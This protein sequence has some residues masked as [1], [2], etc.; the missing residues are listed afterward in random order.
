ML[1]KNHIF[2]IVIGI[3]LLSAHPLAI[4]SAE[5][6]YKGNLGPDRWAELD[7]AFALCGTG[8]SQSPINITKKTKKSPHLLTVHYQPAPMRIIDDG[9]TDLLIGNKH[10]IVDNGHTVQLNF[11]PDQTHET[12]KYK[13]DEFKLIQFHIHTPGENYFNN[14]Q[15][16]MEIHFVHQGEQGKAAAIGVWVKNGPPNATIQKIIDHYPKEHFKEEVIKGT[17]IN[18][19][20]LLPAKLDYYSFM[21]SLT[22]PPCSE[23][24]Q[25]IMMAH[26]VT[27]SPKQIYLLRKLIA[28]INARPIQALNKRVIHYSV[29]K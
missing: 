23:G 10:A 8:T 2:S 29:N 9:E 14:I 1:L 19:I 22:T 17:S 4:A 5:W 28:E 11:N 13:N 15:Y 27:A 26:P 18:P 25:W 6:G 20:E 24:L 12:F 21:G 16:P 3:S 7:P